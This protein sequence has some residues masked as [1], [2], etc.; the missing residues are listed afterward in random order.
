MPTPAERAH[1]SRRRVLQLGAAAVAGIAA[2]RSRER[3]GVPTAAA[4]GRPTPD[5]ALRRLLEGNRRFAAGAPQEADVSAARRAELATGQRPFAALVSCADSRVP[6]ELIFDQGLGDLFV[7][8]IAGNFVDAGI[9]G[10]IEYA[11]GVL[12]VSLVMVL[13]HEACGAVK[14]TLDALAGGGPVSPN[15][16]VLV[17]AI[18]VP[19]LRARELPGDR[20]NNAILSNV[21]FGVER[22]QREPDLAPFIQSG[23]VQVVGGEYMLASGLVELVR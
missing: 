18:S 12:D 11:V 5:E 17:D 1:P 7:C 14:A 21:R 19:V 3:A 6:P 15:I 23:S 20:V 2:A 4:Q 9:A 16:D 22:L 10:S 8:R 13:G